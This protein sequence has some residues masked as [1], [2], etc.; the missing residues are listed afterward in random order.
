M[1]RIEASLVAGGFKVR[2]DSVAGR[3]ALIGRRSQL[4]FGRRLPTFVLVA[5]FKSDASRDHLDRFLDE[6][7][8]YATTVK[9]GLGRGTRAVA[10]AVVESAAEAGDWASRPVAGLSFPVLVDVGGARVVFVD[11]GEHE[12]GPGATLARAHVVPSLGG[13]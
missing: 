3:Q 6:T 11:G 9:G 13:P 5:V 12:R 1:R 2:R 10:V 8:Q 4:A 7:S